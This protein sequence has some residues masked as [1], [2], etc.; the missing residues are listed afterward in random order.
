MTTK[1]KISEQVLYRVNGGVTKTNSVIQK[2]DVVEALSQMINTQFKT[3]HFA[4]TLP[5]GETIPDNLL[6]ADYEAPV[7]TFGGHKSKCTLPIMPVT[8]PRNMGVFSVSPN[9]DFSNEYIPIQAGQ[10]ELLKGQPLISDL[11]GEV[12]YYV[13]GKEIIT[14]QDVTINNVTK[15]YLRLVIFDIA[16]YDDYDSLPIPADYET[17]IVDELVKRFAPIS[18]AA[19]FSDFIAPQPNTKQ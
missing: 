2:E 16:A 15:L 7:V 3:Q 5:S 18:G 6:M 4:V 13:K 8:L 12:G 9:E 14:A 11:L 10:D 19:K 17:T 1:N